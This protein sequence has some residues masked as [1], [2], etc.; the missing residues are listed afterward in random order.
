[1]IR[2]KICG[3]RTVEEAL[4]AV[5][6]G[7]DAVGVLVG[8]HTD[9]QK[10]FVSPEMAETILS[11]LPPFVRGVIVT[12][13]N[14]EAEIVSLIEKTRTSVVQCHSNI[15]MEVIASLRARFPAVLFIAVIHVHGAESIERAKNFAMTANALLLDT[16][17]KNAIGGTGI[18]H[19]WSISAAIVQAMSVPVILAGGLNPDNV[20]TAIATALPYAVDARSGVSLQNGDKDEGKMRAFITQAHSV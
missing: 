6:C 1:M 10:H 7:A 13:H 4:T 9:T 20:R 17:Q 15:S 12:T 5:R 2:V 18:T 14:S 3:N 19:D 16:A 8:P 11:S